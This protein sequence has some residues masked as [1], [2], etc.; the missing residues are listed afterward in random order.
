[1]WIPS[2]FFKAP[3]TDAA[4]GRWPREAGEGAIVPACGAE[5]GPQVAMLR[6]RPRSAC[7]K[8]VP[9]SLPARRYM[10]GLPATKG[11]DGHVRQFSEEIAAH[12]PRAFATG[13]QAKVATLKE[14][15]RFFSAMTC[16]PQ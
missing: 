10:R 3:N 14:L 11:L 1:M 7:P 4:R 5:S 2:F 12:A 15:I 9:A 16:L 6:P 8:Q 13:E